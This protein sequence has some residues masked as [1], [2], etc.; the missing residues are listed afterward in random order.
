MPT[1]YTS[2]AVLEW[3]LER[4]RR[5]FALA[6][7]ALELGDQPFAALLADA[8]GAVLVESLQT[9]AT[10]GDTTGHAETNLCR[11]ASQ[12]WPR[13]FLVTCTIYSSHEPC[14]MCSGAIAWS[15]IGRLVYGLSHVRSYEV[16]GPQPPPRFRTPMP[17]RAIL[18]AVQPPIDVVGPL[19]EDEAARPH[20][21]FRAML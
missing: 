13:A 19:L 3:D 11:D 8:T 9:R 17:C 16:W 5:T 2:P 18:G 1:V 7:R 15:G 10:T 12:G 14:P 21:R 4:L 6:E 20:I